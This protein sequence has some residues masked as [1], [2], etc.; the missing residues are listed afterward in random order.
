[1]KLLVSTLEYSG[2][3]HLK[4]ILN[5]MPKTQE[6]Q[7]YGI[8]QNIKGGNQLYSSDEFGVMGLFSVLPKILKGKKAI[9][10]MVK[11]AK[12]MDK[13]IL[14]DAPAYNL[15]LAK[16]IKENYPNKEIIYYILPKVWA[17]RENRKETIN[18]YIDKQ[19]SIFPF[20]KEFYPNSLYFGNPLMNEINKKWF[21]NSLVK[22]GVTSFLAGSRKSEIKALMPY[23]HKL[24]DKIGGKKIIVIPKDFKNIEIYGD[25]SKFTIYY[26]THKALF[27]SDFAYICS[28]TATL[29]S[30]IIGTPFTLLY[31]TSPIEYF[32]AKTFVKLNSIGLA[33]IIFE[34]LNKDKFHQ[35][36]IQNFTLEQLVESSKNINQQQF[37]KNSQEI[38]EILKG[39]L[40]QVVKEILN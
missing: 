3:I 27:E 32:I 15:P 12:N 40:N 26:D 34:K 7:I 31:K 37:L 4:A 8:F 17:W 19:I 39:D 13:I 6:I 36:F 9:S 11:L 2:N 18:K 25:L 33:N 20:E 24:A 23:F 38:R 21:K 14:I 28:G 10:E 16:R 5:K 1:M 30:A 35:E 22:K 29:E